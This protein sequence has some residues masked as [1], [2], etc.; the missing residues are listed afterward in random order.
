VTIDLTWESPV[1]TNRPNLFVGEQ[2]RVSIFGSVSDED[3]RAL[4]LR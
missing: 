2:E 3:L 4:S 1:L